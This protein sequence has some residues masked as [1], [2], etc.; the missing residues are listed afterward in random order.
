M[1]LF[2][3]TGT[4]NELELLVYRL[5]EK[6]TR[7]NI[8][9]DTRITKPLIRDWVISARSVALRE[10]YMEKKMVPEGFYT[11]LRDLPLQKLRPDVTTTREFFVELPVRLDAGIDEWNVQ[12]F[13]PDDFMR[14]YSRLPLIA[15]KTAGACRY[16]GKDPY[17]TVQENRILV[18]NPA[19]G[20]KRLS[21]LCVTERPV[22]L[23]GMEVFPIPQT[24]HMK[25]E[26][27]VFKDISVTFGVPIDILND[28]ADL[29]IG[30]GEQGKQQG[31]ND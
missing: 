27:L 11:L 30:S 14:N 6:L 12:Y 1:P 29:P 3:N 19:D 18:K 4:M 25:I 13:G 2:F 8:T 7:F 31:Q 16:T 28:A 26:L 5:W 17:Y 22:V 23:D 10:I 15:F 24:V 9:D 20:V 21:M